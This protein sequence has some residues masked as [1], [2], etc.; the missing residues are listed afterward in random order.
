MFTCR[1]RIFLKD[2]DV[3]GSIYFG[4]FFHYALEAFELFLHNQKTNLLDFFSKGYLFPIVH[5]E[6]D[7]ACPLMI[8]DEIFITLTV[9]SIGTRSV[10]IETEMKNLSND[11]IAGKV[12]LVHAFMRKGESKSSEIPQDIR[13]LLTC[14]GEQ[15]IDED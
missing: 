12:T 6:A 1:R 7:Y 14:K 4:S 8:G 9:K 3:T 13:S 10:T 2:V 15:E 11:K 5:A